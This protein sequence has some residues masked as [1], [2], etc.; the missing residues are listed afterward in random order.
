MYKTKS[1]SPLQRIYA[2]K[3]REIQEY[4]ACKARIKAR[5]ELSAGAYI[6]PTK[7]QHDFCLFN[8]DAFRFPDEQNAANEIISLAAFCSSGN[9][10]AS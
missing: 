3:S 10:N 5:A 7:Y 1:A 4:Q 2:R 8:Y 9:R 6:V